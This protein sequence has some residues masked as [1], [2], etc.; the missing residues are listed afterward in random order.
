MSASIAKPELVKL[1]A[2]ANRPRGQRGELWPWGALS[3]PGTKPRHTGADESRRRPAA[4]C[5]HGSS[6]EGG[7]FSSEEAAG[8]PLCPPLPA[9][10]E[11][12]AGGW[13]AE[14]CSRKLPAER[15]KAP[16]GAEEGWLPGRKA[17]SPLLFPGLPPGRAI[18]AA[19]RRV[20]AGRSAE[21]R[22]ASPGKPLR[23]SRQ[24]APPGTSARKGRLAG[25]RPSAGCRLCV[26]GR[27][28]ERRGDPSVGLSIF[29]LACQGDT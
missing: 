8:P 9:R 20:P 6:W 7:L 18:S 15:P 2:G 10:A 22:T 21:G 16:A 12:T 3:A 27:E 14:V 5:A 23:V 25:I 29:C 13:Q 28:G 24:A 11:R 17:S 19:L 4:P 1:P 26:W